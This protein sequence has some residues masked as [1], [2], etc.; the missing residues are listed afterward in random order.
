MLNRFRA[1]RRPRQ[2]SEDTHVE[3]THR[4][5][6]KEAGKPLDDSPVKWMTLRVFI[7]A[8]IVSIGGFIFG[9]D[10]GKLYKFVLLPQRF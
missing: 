2:A 9:Y 10:T 6:E 8:I 5:L 7:M 4:D 1:S 3:S